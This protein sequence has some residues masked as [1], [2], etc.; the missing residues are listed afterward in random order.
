MRKLLFG[1]AVAAIAVIG[2]APAARAQFWMWGGREYCW[3]P[4]GWH[5]PGYY[6]CGY[7]YRR[8]LGWGGGFGWR[9]WTWRDHYHGW[10]GHYGYRGGY[11]GYRG[12]YHGGYRGHSGYHGGNRGGGH[13][14]GGSGHHGGGHHH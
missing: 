4:G 2:A 1:A 8:G 10:R 11:G 3:Y 14:G 12:G 13:H 6:W 5:G 9:G 7:R